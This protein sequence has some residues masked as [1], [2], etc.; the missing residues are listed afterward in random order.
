MADDKISSHSG[1]FILPVVSVSTFLI[2]V[3]FGTDTFNILSFGSSGMFTAI[4]CSTLS[5]VLYLYIEKALIHYFKPIRFMTDS[6]DPRFN[7]AIAAIIPL[8]S[9][10]LLFMIIKYLI[11]ANT[12][13][14]DF[15]VLSINIF[16]KIFDNIGENFWSSLL[17]V[18]ITNLLWFFGIHGSDAL[19]TINGHI[20]VPAD[21]ANVLAVMSGKIPVHIYTKTLFDVFT[22]IGGCGT[23]LSLLIAILLF[24]R[25]KSS[26]SVAKLSLLPV[27]F[28]INE[29]MVFGLP[30]IYNPSLLIPFIL[31]PVV[32]F[33][34]SSAAMASGLVP[35]TCHSVEWT[36]PVIIGGYKATGSIRGV[37]LQLVIVAAG[38][39]I[40][41]PFVK[42][43]DRRREHQAV[44]DLENLVDYL[45]SS[46]AE[47]KDIM[48]SEI[49]GAA[50]GMA[51]ILIKDLKLAL[52]NKEFFMMY[53]PQFNAD[54]KMFGAEALLRWK[55][56]E[57]GFIYPPLIIK[58]SQEAGLMKELEEYIFIHSQ[59]AI[60]ALPKLRFSINATAISLRDPQFIEYLTSTYQLLIRQGT[61]VCI[62]IT[63]QSS[64]IT[65]EIMLGNLDK[66][67]KCGFSL[68]IDD[69]SM[70]HT[71]IKYL[72]ESNFDVVKLDG[73]LS[74]HMLEDTKTRYIIDSIVY[75]SKS[76]GFSVIAEFVENDEQKQCLEGLGCT[77]YQG[78]L[79]SP[80]LTLEEL[81]Q[82]Y[83]SNI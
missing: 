27:I 33:L 44:T 40:Y 8:I 73:S 18:F 17:Y 30:I 67:I 11:S 62:E 66:L 10:D 4:L 75:L 59:E 46:E 34:I 56:K 36:T 3:G 58:L 45:K 23:L 57:L 70:G 41:M 38:V 54:K 83:N 24:S 51:R 72:Q 76:S 47:S 65:D 16:N 69:F 52:D 6:S 64:F 19:G 82:K 32:S 5:S 12:D 60:R 74:K 26:R 29:I 28:N 49:E 15:W 63:E 55:H 61:N 2:A 68:A 9:V 42:L 37:I 22:L 71:S 79:Y 13:Y 77:E 50:G 53:Q 25:Q 20:F 43:Y 48:L 1:R 31:V 81:I 21:K 7:Q 80:A 35:V 78:Y 14:Y 39:L